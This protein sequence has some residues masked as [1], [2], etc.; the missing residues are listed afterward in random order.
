[1]NKIF[2][3]LLIS[4]FVLGGINAGGLTKICIDKDPPS[5]MN[6]SLTLTATNN[7]INLNW[8]AATDIPD[9]SGI[10]YYDIWGSDNGIDFIKIA[11]TSETNY[12][13]VSL[14]Y[15]KT[16]YYMI[17]AFD[18]A[19]HNEGEEALS[20]SF[21]LSSPTNGPSPGGG[22]SDISYWKCEEWSECINGTQKRVCEDIFETESNRTETKECF[23]DFVSSQNNKTIILDKNQ[24]SSSST[25]F[26]TG[27]V[28]GIGNFAKSGAGAL[29]LS[30]LVLTGLAVVTVLLRKKIGKKLSK[31]PESESVETF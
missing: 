5:L 30:I 29:T 12:I 13:D 1:M 3:I 14:S 23:P 18:L 6:S 20:N 22:S 17:H 4:I 26:F 24:E 15:G 11:N 31:E 16:Y 25:N 28:T 10:D 21:Y 2:L 27:A 8:I 19:G 9:C 7:N